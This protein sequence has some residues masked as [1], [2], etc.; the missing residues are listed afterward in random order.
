M[1]EELLIKVF[2]SAIVSNEIGFK[3]GVCLFLGFVSARVPVV[4]SFPFKSESTASLSRFSSERDRC[5]CQCSL[6]DHVDSVSQKTPQTLQTA[7]ERHHGVSVKLQRRSRSEVRVHRHT[8]SVLR[9]FCPRTAG[10]HQVT[11]CQFLSSSP[12][13]VFLKDQASSHLIDTIIQLAHK[14]LL[15]GLYKKHLKD[16]LVDLALHPI[17]NFP[18]QRLTAASAKYKMVCD[19]APCWPQGEGLDS[20]QDFFLSLSLKFRKLFDELLQGVEAIL[21]A[22]HMGVIVQLAE[23]CAESEERQEEL[24]Q[25]LLHVSVQQCCFNY[26]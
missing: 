14:S 13:L 26:N 7:T 20:H 4:D 21:A 8:V 16:Q 23:G 3:H 2:S 19:T 6:P 24:M 22:G 9:D 18:I 5:R 17:A 11:F 10:G 15:C 1:N 12:L 25:C